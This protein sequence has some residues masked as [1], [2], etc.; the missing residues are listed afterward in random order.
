ML[1]QITLPSNGNE[2]T[3]K[4]GERGGEGERG[5]KCVNELKPTPFAR[6]VPIHEKDKRRQII[7]EGKTSSGAA[8]I[9]QVSWEEFDSGKEHDLDDKVNEFVG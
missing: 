2:A 7:R 9:R 3:T 8:M 6:D 4:G 5:K 1:P